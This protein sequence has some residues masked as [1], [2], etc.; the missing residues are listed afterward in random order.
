[1]ARAALV[2]VFN[3][4]LCGAGSAPLSGRA[5]NMQLLSR[6][7]AARTQSEFFRRDFLFS[8]FARGAFWESQSYFFSDK[9]KLTRN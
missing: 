7:S 8:I 5:R 1:M 2:I 3:S 4:V 9:R 6:L